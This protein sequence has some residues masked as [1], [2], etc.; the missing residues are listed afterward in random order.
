[1]TCAANIAVKPVITTTQMLESMIVNPCSTLA[2]SSDVANT[3]YDGTN[4]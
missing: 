2:E 4:V 1:M 3:V